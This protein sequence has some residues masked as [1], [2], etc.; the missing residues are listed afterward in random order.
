VANNRINPKTLAQLQEAI[1]EL[2][3]VAGLDGGVADEDDFTSDL[4]RSRPSM[5]IGVTSPDYGDGKTTV[6]MALAGS[7]SR[8]FGGG[9]TL[10]D[11]DFHTHSVEKEFGLQGLD[12]FTEVLNGTTALG[13]ASYP[14]SNGQLHVIPAGASTS[15]PARMARSARLASVVSE[16]KH[17]NTFVVLDLPATL[18]SMTGPALAQRCDAVIV[19]ARYGETTRQD[20]D[21]TLHLL[22]D[23]YVLGVVVNR[24]STS[25][26][27]YVQR[28]LGMRN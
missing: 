23:A 18:R 24:R 19:V 17:S 26:P 4:P 1:R 2:H 25:I 6:A 21:R 11:A 14:V 3:I 8:D 12:G 27:Q 13:D 16:I 22:K 9:V 10:V 7:L 20:L 28:L 15:E 5:A